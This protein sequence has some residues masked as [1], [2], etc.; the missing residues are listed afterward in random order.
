MVHKYSC[1]IFITPLDSFPR[2]FPGTSPGDPWRKHRQKTH[3]QKTQTENTER[4][5]RKHRQK[6]PRAAFPISFLTPCGKPCWSTRT[7]RCGASRTWRL[8]CIFGSSWAGRPRAASQ[9]RMVLGLSTG[10]WCSTVLGP[11]RRRPWT[12]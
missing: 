4:K 2:D 3:R 5:Q 10:S 8:R 12:L 9:T 1:G 6:T 7:Q 11:I